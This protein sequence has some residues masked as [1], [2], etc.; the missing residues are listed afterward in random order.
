MSQATYR[1]VN[2]VGLREIA[3][4]LGE[5]HTTAVNSGE[6]ASYWTDEMLRAWAQ[7]AECQLA[8]GNAATIEISGHN[9]VTGD[10]TCYT[11]S[12]AGLDVHESETDDGDET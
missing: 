2:A 9:S 1:T 6:G 8:E 11:I 3:E 10:P 12:D 4:F 5:N 7:D